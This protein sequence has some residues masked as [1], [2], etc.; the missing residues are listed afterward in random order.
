MKL[1]EDEFFM[2]AISLIEKKQN[3]LKKLMDKHNVEL[4]QDLD[5]LLGKL[6]QNHPKCEGMID[7]IYRC[8]QNLND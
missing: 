4:V 3:L 8:Q 1:T 6:E 7:L 2:I 5:T